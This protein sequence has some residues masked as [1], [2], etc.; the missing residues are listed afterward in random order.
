MPAETFGDA[1]RRV[2]LHVPDAPFGLVREW[3]QH[4]YEELCKRR[5]WGFLRQHAQLSIPTAR[6]LTATFAAFSTT[7]TSA[8]AFLATDVGLQIRVGNV[9]IYTIQ[10][11]VDAS[12]VT[13]DM[14]WTGTAGA[15]TA[16]ILGVYQ[17]LPADFGAFELLVDTTMQRIVPWWFT[18]EDLARVDPMRFSSG[19]LQRCL[20]SRSLST[21]PSTLG[22]V[23]YEWWPAPTTAKSFPYYYRQQAQ[24]LADTAPLLGVVTARV[25][26]L[27]ARA[28]CAAWPGTVERKNPY[29]SLALHA[30]LKDEFDAECA[31]LELRDDDQAQQSWVGLPWHRWGV[32]DLGFGD[33]HTLRAT[34]AGIGSYWGN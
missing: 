18:Q 22:Q 21:V 7:V 23:Q 4:A 31:K 2:R 11:V 12:T 6:S 8:A 30:K 20:V 27:G 13:I 24:L 17:T 25:L 14:P 19:D 15:Q 9:P 10:T 29:F 33:T 5:P 1:W 34:D 16:Q 32:D 26:G 28:E 3:T